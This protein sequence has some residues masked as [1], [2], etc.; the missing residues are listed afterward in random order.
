MQVTSGHVDGERPLK[1]SIKA[2]SE[3]LLDFKIANDLQKHY[4]AW[5]ASIH[6]A[7]PNKVGNELMTMMMN[8]E[9]SMTTI[10]MS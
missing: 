9:F 4:V 5:R 6:V 1:I 8:S 2:M 3:D 10:T 7:D